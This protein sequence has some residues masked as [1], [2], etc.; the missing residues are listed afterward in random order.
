MTI[1]ISVT[2]V[3]KDGT[4]IDVLAY[5]AKF[6]SSFVAT[7]RGA[8][9]GTDGISGKQY[10][11]VDAKNAGVVFDAGKTDW[12]YDMSSHQVSGS[13][14]ALRFGTSTTLDATKHVFTQ[15]TDLKISGLGLETSAE[16]NALRSGLTSSDT[17][18]LLDLLKKNSISFSGSTG[19]DV[20]KSFGLNDVLDG[21]AGN[22]V[23]SGEGGNDSLKGGAGNDKINGGIGNDTLYGNAG[24]DVLNGSTGNDKLNG[25]AGT[26][27]LQGGSGND[28][29]LGGAGKDT[30]IFAT[31]SGK[32]TVLDFDA[33]SSTSGDILSLDKAV[34]ASFTAVKAAATD[35]ADGVL[36][37]FGT[38]SILLEGVEKADL[39]ANDFFFV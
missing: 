16:A 25:G 5:L 4:G 3:N 23:L 18:G 30:F 28:I 9:S 6:D 36:I 2:D 19:N 33:G 20:F 13:L 29:L 32:D 1:N 37:K 31:G 8:F 22:D 11:A 27:T 21:G 15:S 35:T 10:A 39:H 26:D 17:T 7:G 24:N 12:A 38:G 14:S 34:L